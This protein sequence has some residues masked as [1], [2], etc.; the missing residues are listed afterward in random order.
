MDAHG[1]AGVG[2]PLI[3]ELRDRIGAS[4]VLEPAVEGL[5]FEPTRSGAPLG[6]AT[7]VSTDALN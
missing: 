4:S 2:N 6:Y 3:V 5:Q 7:A 1:T